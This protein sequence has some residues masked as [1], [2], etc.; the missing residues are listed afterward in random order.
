MKNKECCRE[1]DHH[2]EYEECDE[3]TDK[4]DCYFNPDLECCKS[5]EMTEDCGCYL[6]KTSRHE[7]SYKE[8]KKKSDNPEKT[9]RIPVD[10]INPKE[11][12]IM[13]ANAIAKRL[14]IMIETNGNVDISV[15]KNMEG[16]IESS[17]HITTSYDEIF[18][19]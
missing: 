12:I 13:L 4:C 8:S 19:L 15:N 7:F 14:A 10:P 6:V 5:C 1:C 17:M 18:I 2:N 9:I 11:E 3:C 16:E